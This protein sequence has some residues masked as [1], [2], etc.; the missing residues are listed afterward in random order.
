MPSRLQKPEKIIYPGGVIEYK[1]DGVLHREN[2]PAVIQSDGYKDWRL[3]GEFHRADG[4]AVMYSDG[5]R[6]WYVDG[7]YTGEEGYIEY[8]LE[9]YPKK[10]S[11]ENL[12]N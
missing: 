8:L 9:Y 3:N 10:I 11:P 6:A 1:L 12:I 5:R 7:F 4:P 2:G